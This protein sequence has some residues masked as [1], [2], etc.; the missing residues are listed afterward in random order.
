M[1]SGGS[2]SVPGGL[3]RRTA[4]AWLLSTPAVLGLGLFIA[5]PF[6]V[7]VGL[8]FTDHRLASPLPTSWVAWSNYREL[9]C[10]PHSRFW[11]ALRN[12]ALFAAV[13][14]PLQTTLALLLALALNAPLRAM[15]VFRA[16]FFL[17]VVYPMALVAVVWQLIYAPGPDGLLNGVLQRLSGGAWQAAPFWSV[18]DSPWT[19]M[20][21]IM[22]LSLWQGLGFQ[23]VILLAALQG[24]P[25]ELYEAAA[26]DGARARARFWHITVPQLRG[27]LMFTALITGILALRLFDQ[28]RI[29]TP[30]GGPGQTTTTVMLEMVRAA[31]P[32]GGYRLGYAAALAVV[33]FALV[34]GVTV[35]QLGIA[36]LRARRG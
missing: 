3:G 4:A 20:P 13:V 6:L 14:V 29:L 30:G 22:L 5:L 26:I 10:D 34:C 9:F 7:A 19:A 33:F 17:P 12:V 16:C 8:S 15:P 2:R 27:A 21:A 24:V 36:R 28:P 35:L 25:G 31:S 11:P 32:H 1:T 18:L 23:T